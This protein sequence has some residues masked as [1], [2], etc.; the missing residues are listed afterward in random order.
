MLKHV[1]ATCRWLY[2]TEDNFDSSN[3]DNGGYGRRVVLQ[4]G[5]FFPRLLD[6]T[7]ADRRDVPV[8][9]T[10]VER[11]GNPKMSEHTCYAQVFGCNFWEGK[12]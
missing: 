6:G 8:M 2:R 12:E 10:V 3:F 11:E 1:C 9:C 7:G 4:C 5:R